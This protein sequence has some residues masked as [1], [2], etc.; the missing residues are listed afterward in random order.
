M[1]V[2]MNL[3]AIKKLL[4]PLILPPGI[5]VVFLTISCIWFLIQRYYK[6]AFVNFLIG[7][8]IWI[9]S[10]S[11]VSD[12]MIGRLENAFT[13]PA[14]PRGDVIIL[15]A[16][17]AYDREEDPSGIIGPT[18][19][20]LGR[21][22]AAAKLQKVLD[23]PII[24]SDF[25]GDAVIKSLRDLGIPSHKIILE[26]KSR[27]T[28]QNALYT[29]ALCK[30]LRFKEPILVTSA[31]HMK[32]S[33]MSFKKVAMTVTPYP[34]DF[35]TLKD[36]RYKWT[37]YLPGLDELEKSTIALHEYLGLLFYRFAY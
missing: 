20:N 35:K 5:F 22:M 27:D 23:V 4:T 13:I 8:T 9:L 11:P 24:V 7:L 16:G 25:R 36:K 28:I 2:M 14:H 30:K 29:E 26:Q 18:G 1:L 15:L 37:E 12:T 3:F 33:V 19:D 21:L 31:Y 34:A 17:G 6:A 10:I 32:R